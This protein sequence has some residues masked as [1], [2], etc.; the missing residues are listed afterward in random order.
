MDYTYIETEILETLEGLEKSFIELNKY[1]VL[2]FVD[3]NNAVF[4]LKDNLEPTFFGALTP[5]K[6][7]KRE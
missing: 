4:T 2:T 7:F 3:Q 6:H 5:N 1:F